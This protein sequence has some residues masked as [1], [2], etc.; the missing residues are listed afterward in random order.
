[1]LTAFSFAPKGKFKMLLKAQRTV[2][3]EPVCKMDPSDKEGTM[4]VK[5]T[6]FNAAVSVKASV[7]CPTCACEQVSFVC[8]SWTLL[9]DCYGGLMRRC[10]PQNPI[11]KSDRC[12][13]NGDLVCGKCQ[14]HDG[15]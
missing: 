5:P 3:K 14:C 7:L 10:F 9:A 2:D 11:E 4:R 13:R 8:L 6:T 1:M 12:H 15:W